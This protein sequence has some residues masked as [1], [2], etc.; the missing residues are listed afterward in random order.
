MTRV[1]FYHLLT[2]PLEVALSGLLEKALERDM[3]AVVMTVS[4]ERATH[5]D[6]AL[7]TYRN[8]SFL[9]HGC[10]G[11]ARNAEHQ[12]VW[13][14]DTDDNPNG[15]RLLVLVDRADCAGIDAFERVADIFDGHDGEA[16]A[17]A[18]RRWKARSRTGRSGSGRRL[19]P[20]VPSAP[21]ARS[22]RR[23]SR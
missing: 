12:P 23:P 6:S 22:S 11:Q 5:L 7:W 9:P 15:A 13:I 20:S 3:R 4:R 10:V 19:W 2:S 21:P 17:A 18:R 8:E 14:A 1:D 16:V